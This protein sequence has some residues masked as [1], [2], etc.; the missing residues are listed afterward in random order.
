[1]TLS[2]R[3]I[4]P[5]V[6]MLA[7]ARL[8]LHRQNSSR[9]L[10]AMLVVPNTVSCDGWM[11][12]RMFISGRRV[13][14]AMEHSLDLLAHKPRLSCAILPFSQVKLAQEGV[15]W[16][17]LCAILIASASILLL[18]RTEEPLQHEQ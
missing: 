2:E 11:M 17:L 12:A 3:C 15:E 4:P 5:A 10:D 1:M 9:Y 18:E 13:L 7:G 14:V 16:F 6:E 8:S